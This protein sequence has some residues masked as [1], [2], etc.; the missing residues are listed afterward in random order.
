MTDGGIKVFSSDRTELK[1]IPLLPGMDLGGFDITWR[2]DD[3]GFFLVGG[4]EIYS[5]AIAKSEINLVETNF[6]NHFGFP[7]WARR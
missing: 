1:K 6:V 2:P 5:V 3:S 7:R 4:R